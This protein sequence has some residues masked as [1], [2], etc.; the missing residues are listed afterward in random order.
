MDKVFGMPPVAYRKLFYAKNYSVYCIEEGSNPT[1]AMC[2]DPEPSG[3]RQCRFCGRSEPD[4]SFDKEAHAVPKLIGNYF[5][6]SKTECDECNAFF[7]RTV[8][9]DLANHLGAARVLLGIT[10]KNRNLKYGSGDREVY[11][12]RQEGCV[13]LI[14]APRY[15]GLIVDPERQRIELCMKSPK[16]SRS[17]VYKALVKMAL[18]LLPL[19]EMSHFQ[20]TAAWLLSSGR[21]CL[22]N[23]F[24]N[25]QW[26]SE[27]F[28]PRAR[29]RLAFVMLVRNANAPTFLPY[30]MFVAAIG[31][32]VFQIA[33]PCTEKDRN[34]FD[35]TILQVAYPHVVESSP[36]ATEIVSTMKDMRS[37]ITTNGMERFVYNYIAAEDCPKSKWTE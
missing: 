2:L 18:S 29:P 28:V 9:R 34:E 13:K 10:P 7:G 5:L 22:D 1:K 35:A 32:L 8:E 4:V 23:N 12:E 31:S 30:Y 26:M 14:P 25:Y 27:R 36:Y 15:A 17:K 20:D 3:S 37:D 24:I 21:E 16:Y 33:V 6:F 11:L 19:P